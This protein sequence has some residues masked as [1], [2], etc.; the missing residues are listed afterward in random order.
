MCCPPRLEVS[1][2]PFVSS[3]HEAF[4]P[5]QR[6][7]RGASPSNCPSMDVKSSLSEY[8]LTV[9][10][11]DHIKHEMVTI[12]VLKGNKLKLIA[13]AWHMEE[14]CHYE[15]VINFPPHDID[16]GGVHAQLDASGL[17]VISVRR[18]P[19]YHGC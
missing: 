8:T 19:R 6:E 11:P 5:M 7:R 15:W 12:S 16:M 2:Q 14:E 9:Q 10:L 18:R 1:S 13:D 4:S 17:L 3:S